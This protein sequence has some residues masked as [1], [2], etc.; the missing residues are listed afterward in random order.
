[1]DSDR[2]FEALISMNEKITDRR[3]E[4]LCERWSVRARLCTAPV[5]AGGQ[6]ILRTGEV[7]PPG[8]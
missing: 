5:E 7:V 6:Q 4:I 2:P 1:M 8:S 3:D